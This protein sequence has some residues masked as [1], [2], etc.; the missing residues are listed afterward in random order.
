MYEAIG[1]FSHPQ[2]IQAG[3]VIAS[4]LIAIAVNTFITFRW[5][6]EGQNLNVQAAMLHV[7]GDLAASVGVVVAA[8]IVLSTGWLYADPLISVGIA[9]LVSWEAIRIV[10]STVNILLEGVPKGDQP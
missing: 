10:L 3:L 4:A 5:R 8:V 7:L 2:S 1:R 6:G 9:L